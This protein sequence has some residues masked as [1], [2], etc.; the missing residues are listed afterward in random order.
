MAI[1]SHTTTHRRLPT[2]FFSY[3]EGAAPWGAFIQPG[4]GDRVE[5]ASEGVEAA[6]AEV[7][8]GGEGAGIE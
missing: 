7:V 1:V 4:I 2:P 5:L 3:H 6:I 8:C